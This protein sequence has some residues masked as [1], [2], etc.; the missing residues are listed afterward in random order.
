VLAASHFPTH[1]TIRDFRALH[2]KE[3]S[4]LLVQVVRLAR[5]MGLVKR[6]LGF[7]QFSLRGLHRVQ[8]ESKL[9]GLALS[10]RRMAALQAATQ[11]HGPSQGSRLTTT[12]TAPM[13]C[14]A[15]AA[16]HHPV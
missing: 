11:A 8:A 1:R 7:R 3:L 13:H 10:L 5:E 2:L 9:V 15:R 16:R 14:M 4:E 12:T 6:V